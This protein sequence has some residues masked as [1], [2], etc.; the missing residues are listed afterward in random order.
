MTAPKP[1]QT[2]LLLDVM[3]TLVT[4]PFYD[5]IPRFLNLALSELR[6][7]RDINAFHD[8]ER[9]FI[10]EQEY[11][12]RFFRGERVLDV[13]GMKA[14]LRKSVKFLPG[15]EKTLQYLRDAKVPMHALS[16]YSA[17][18]QCIED[19]TGL[20]RFL[21]WTFVSCKTGFRKP[22]PEAYLHPLEVLSLR[23]TDCLFID[24]RPQ[25]VD[26]ALS[27]GIPSLLRTP[28]MD[29]E[30]ALVE[31]GVLRPR[32]AHRRCDAK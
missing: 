4:E 16:N 12:Q 11:A 7:L 19:A 20:S 3:S 29:L 25:N 2:T 9:G 5:E 30:Q 18:Y 24:D 1:S 14:T 17:W 26:S 32:A 22:E 8:F 31:H 6:G 23:P 15:V 27:V 13:D 21:P 10:T 28:D